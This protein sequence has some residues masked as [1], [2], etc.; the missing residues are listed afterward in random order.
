MEASGDE[1]HLVLTRTGNTGFTLTR[2]MQGLENFLKRLTATG[3]DNLM[4]RF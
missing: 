3:I 4:V 1:E 2:W